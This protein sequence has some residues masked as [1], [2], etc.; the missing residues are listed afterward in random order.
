MAKEQDILLRFHSGR[1][2]R[3]IALELRVSRNTVAKVIA[4]YNLHSA[5]L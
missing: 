4:A 1:S 3:A 5:Q 2:Q